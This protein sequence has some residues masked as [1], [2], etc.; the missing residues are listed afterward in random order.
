VSRQPP[1][2]V[3]MVTASMMQATQ[4][5][6]LRFDPVNLRNDAPI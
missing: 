2:T 4:M 1:S 6:L 5:T 3:I